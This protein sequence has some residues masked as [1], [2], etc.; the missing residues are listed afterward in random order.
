MFWLNIAIQAV[1]SACSRPPAGG[2][3]GA[4]V[5]HADVVQAE[6]AALEHVVARG[7][8]AVHPP[9]EVQQQPGESLLEKGQVH[10]AE[11]DLQV[12]QKQGREGVHRRV[13]VA[14]VPLVGRHLAVRVEVVL[15]QHQ[16]DL[17]FR[18]VRVD[19]GQRNAVERQVPGGVPGVLP[20]VGHRHDVVVEHVEPRLVAAS[21]ARRRPQRVDM[22]LT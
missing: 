9:G 4:A 7:I 5:E 16:V 20:L 10:L 3:R 12:L 18:E 8:L 21:P 22:A 13:H 19:H 11:V 6:E 14:E 2:Q 17:A 1:P 15:G